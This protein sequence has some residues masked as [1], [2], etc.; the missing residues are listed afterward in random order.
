MAQPELVQYLFVW[1]AFTAGQRSAGAVQRRGRLG[2]DLF[3]FHRR[4][5]QRARQRFHHHLEQSDDGVELGGVEPIEQL[6]CPLS[7]RW[8]FHSLKYK[9][10]ISPGS[11]SLGLG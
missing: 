9:P 1:D 11:A 10:P 4:Q 2:R 7:V 8:F 6:M 5:R 3:L